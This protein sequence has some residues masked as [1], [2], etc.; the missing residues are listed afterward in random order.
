MWQ[1]ARLKARV[2]RVQ[3]KYRADMYP[4]IPGFFQPSVADSSALPS[5]YPS[6]QVDIFLCKPSL[7]IT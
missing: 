1:A 5:H 2:L 4:L 6:T 3:L 7:A